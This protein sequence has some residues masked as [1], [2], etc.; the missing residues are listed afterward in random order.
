MPA[1]VLATEAFRPLLKVTLR[2]HAAPESIAIVL[3]RNPEYFER[4]LLASV[5]EKVLDE[6]VRRLTTGRGEIDHLVE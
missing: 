3:K 1:V 5:A 4:T 6:S 2:A